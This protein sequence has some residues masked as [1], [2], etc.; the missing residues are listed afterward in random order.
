MPLP[1]GLAYAGLSHALAHSVGALFHIPHGRAVGI[2]LP[3]ALEYI[4]SNPPLPNAPEP[5][6][7]LGTAARFVGIDAKSDQEGAEMLIQ[8]TRELEKEIGEP[9]SLKEAGITEKQMSEGI[10]ALVR[11]GSSDPNMYTTPC[12]CKGEKL[13]QLFLEMWEGR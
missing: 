9:L 12:E 11:L 13:R 4:S 1:Y 3:Y 10:D 8:R 6:E 2:G 7:R 5:V